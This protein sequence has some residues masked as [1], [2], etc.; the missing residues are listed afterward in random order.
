MYGCMARYIKWITTG[1]RH[2]KLVKELLDLFFLIPTFYI[3]KVQEMTAVNKTGA[4][5]METLFLLISVSSHVSA[6]FNLRHH[7][8][9]IVYALNRISVIGVLRSTH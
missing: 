5:S 2:A 3:L 9:S 1:L 4:T 6:N 8:L 7:I